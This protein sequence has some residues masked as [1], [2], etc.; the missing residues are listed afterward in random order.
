[1]NEQHLSVFFE[2]FLWVIQTQKTFFL[3][4]FYFLLLKLSWEQSLLNISMKNW[5]W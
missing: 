1:M 2:L 5:V 4:D 3:L